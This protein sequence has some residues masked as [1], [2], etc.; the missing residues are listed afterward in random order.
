MSEVLVKL[1]GVSKKFTKQ[2]RKSLW[3]GTKDSL[4]SLVGRRPDTTRLRDGEFW[5]LQDVSFEVRRGETLGLIGPNG[6]GKSTL[7][8]MLCG[9]YPPDKGRITMRGRIGALIALGAGFHPHMSGRENIHL[10]GALMGLTR[11]ETKRKEEAIIDFSEVGELIDAPV[12]TYSSGM[13]VRLGYSIAAQME[14][15]VLIVDE[16]LAVGDIGFHTKCLN[17][18]AEVSNK[19]AVLFVSHAMPQ[20]AR[21]SHS[22]HLLVKGKTVLHTQDSGVAIEA[23][24][25][26]FQREKTMEVAGEVN[27]IESVD[28]MSG[29]LSQGGVWL[30]EYGKAMVLKLV[31]L[32]REPIRGPII[33]T[34][35]FDKDTKV[36]AQSY[37]VAIGLE[38]GP[39]R[40]NVEITIPNLYFSAGSFSLG[41][42]LTEHVDGVRG[43]IHHQLLHALSLQVIGIETTHAPVTLPSV[44]RFDSV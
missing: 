31:L 44:W 43:R 37:N 42:T 23:Y 2:L 5:A 14:P 32:I 19:A 13:K 38:F 16:V 36:V 11:A 21:V 6:S 24:L 17:S 28:L 39:G 12:A 33:F 22:V 3:Y 30:C 18:I 20:I 27:R 25:G 34:N 1:E 29:V 41:F 8:R 35:F 10:N 26:L 7:L 9:V 15:D 4:A 40:H